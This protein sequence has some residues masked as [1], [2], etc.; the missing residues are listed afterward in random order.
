MSDTVS[1]TPKQNQAFL[2]YAQLPVQSTKRLWET[3]PKMGGL[4]EYQRPSARTLERWCTKYQWVERA[5]QIHN[6]AKDVAVRKTV[7]ELVLTKEEILSML[8]AGILRFGQQLQANTQGKIDVSDFEKLWKMMRIEMGL[9][10]EITKSEVA[11][12]L[13]QG[14]SDDELVKMLESLTKK[15]KEKL[16]KNDN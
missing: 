10:V 3:W 6:K 9:P 15:Y 5:K 12:D 7:A 4:S 11:V 8:R 13:Y 14:V 1:E 2:A 16:N